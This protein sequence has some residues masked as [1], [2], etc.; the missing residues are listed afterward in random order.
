MSAKG[1][2]ASRAGNNCRDTIFSGRHLPYEGGLLAI[3][4]SCVELTW[5]LLYAMLGLIAFVAP[6]Y[7]HDAK[8]LLDALDL[9]SCVLICLQLLTC[10][11]SF[12]AIGAVKTTYAFLQD[13]LEGFIY[14]FIYLI[15]ANIS[16]YLWLGKIS[17]Q[18]IL[19][20][21]VILILL[22]LMLQKIFLVN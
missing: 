21:L 9:F 17:V 3:G 4:G 15:F 20:Y 14:Y 5:V 12:N 22:S 10:M 7:V 16:R 2:C 8:L 13:F 19:V 6:K 1:S 11:F 18:R